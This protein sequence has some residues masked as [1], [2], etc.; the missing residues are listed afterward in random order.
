MKQGILIA[1]FGLLAA[2]ATAGWVRK[3][4]EPLFS[5]EPGLTAAPVTYASPAV[6]RQPARVTR[7]AS[8]P[9]RTVVRRGRPTNHS[10]AIVA[11]GAGFGAAVGGL[12]GGGRGAAIGALSGG[13]AGFIYDRLTH[14]HT[15]GF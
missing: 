6:Y 5:N 11:G 8:V 1:A 4:G 10:V 12:A 2:V 9:A 13:T 14:N 7:A 15:T 3:P